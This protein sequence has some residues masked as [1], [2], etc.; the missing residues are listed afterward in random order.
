MEM[1][2]RARL[3]GSVVVLLMLG[4]LTTAGAAANYSSEVLADSPLGYWRLGES[5][6]SVASDSSGNSRNGTYVGPGLG[7]AGAIDG[8]SDTAATVDGNDYVNLPVGAGLNP[9]LVSAEAWVRTTASSY[10]LILRSRG[11][12]YGLQMGAGLPSFFAFPNSV[13]IVV[14]SGTTPV[15]DGEWHHLVGTFDT[16]VARVYVDGV[17]AGSAIA[18][19]PGNVYYQ[20]SG[21][22]IGRDG[23]NPDFYFLGTLDEVALYGAALSPARVLAHYEAGLGITNEAPTDI[24]LSN[25]QVAENSAGGSEVGTLSATDTV[26]DTHSFSLVAGIGDEDN[27]SFAIAGDSLQLAPATSPDYETQSSYSVRIRGTDAGGLSTEEAFT[28]TVTNV[29]EWAFSGFRQPVDNLPTLNLVKAGSAVPV[30]FSLGGD[31]GLNIF[32]AGYPK[33]EVIACDSAALVD[34]I[35]QT[36]SSGSSVL[37]Y[38]AATDTYSY[39]WKT[40]KAWSGCRQLVAKFVDAGTQRANFKMK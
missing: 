22:T 7:A 27:A 5:V 13:E 10:Q 8:D 39:V 12:G 18:N 1:G 9:A 32:A 30:K 25:D 21:I 16:S 23:S 35:E 17:L 34:G 6:G 40:D 14:A 36:V 2:M 31:K 29:A 4:S 38:D 20:T 28:I 26:G 15:N 24:A 33:S 37:T 3:A 19:T 11:H